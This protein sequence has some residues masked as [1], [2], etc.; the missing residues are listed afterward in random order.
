MTPLQRFSG[1]LATVLLAAGCSTGSASPGPIASRSPLA[2]IVWQTCPESD[3]FTGGSP[4]LVC[5]TLP[6]PLDYANP[7]GPTI[8]IAI[9]M[10]PAADQEG[11]V[12]SLFLNFGGPG[13]SGINV[14]ASNGRGLVPSEIGNRFDL[15]T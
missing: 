6:V 2:D 12:G 10:L 1:L 7:D 9:A 4:E 15:V 3:P 11:R 8:D 5:A 14:L 13:A